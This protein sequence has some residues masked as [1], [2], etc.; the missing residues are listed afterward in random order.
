MNLDLH[1]ELYFFEWNRKEHLASSANLPVVILT[2]ISGG[3]LFLVRTF[4]YSANLVTIIFVLLAAATISAQVA[5][6]YFLIRSLHGYWY[7]Q[8]PSSDKLQTYFNELR[9]YHQG[10]G[11]PPEEAQKDFDE[12]LQARFAE[13]TVANRGNNTQTAGALHQATGSIIVALIFG[14]VSFFP[15]LA[16]SL[17]R[18]RHT[19]A[20]EIEGVPKPEAFMPEENQ[21]QSSPQQPQQQPA[22]S[23]QPPKPEGPPNELV[24]KDGETREKR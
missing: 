12:Y 24:R 11:S 19:P 13:A 8:V 7:E 23:Q 6:I 15:Y 5:A 14:A 9:G 22:E 16:E 18:E 21:E 17:A 1:K 2:V 3:V 10:L 20:A 4:P